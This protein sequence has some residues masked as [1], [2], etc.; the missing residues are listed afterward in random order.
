MGNREKTG[1]PVLHSL[2]VQKECDNTGEILFIYIFFFKFFFF[3]IF[4]FYISHSELLK[5]IMGAII[6]TLI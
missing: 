2:L 4:V 5:S 3:A 6:I 1:F